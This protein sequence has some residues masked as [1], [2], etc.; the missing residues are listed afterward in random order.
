VDPRHREGYKSEQQSRRESR[1]DIEKKLRKVQLKAL[2]L[3]SIEPSK[4]GV[5]RWLSNPP[6]R[7]A[8]PGTFD[9]VIKAA[10]GLRLIAP[11]D[12]LQTAAI[13]HNL[14]KGL[15]SFAG[16]KG[17]DARDLEKTLRERGMWREEVF[18]RSEITAAREN[19][20]QKL[21][22][23]LIHDTFNVRSTPSFTLFSSRFTSLQDQLVSA[24]WISREGIRRSPMV[25]NAMISIAMGLE[26]LVEREQGTLGVI[27]LT[28]EVQSF[29]HQSGLTLPDGCKKALTHIYAN[30][31]DKELQ[32]LIRDQGLGAEFEVPQLHEL[33]AATDQLGLSVR[34]ELQRRYMYSSQKTTHA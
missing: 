14:K 11:N 19:H 2:K 26:K 30:R 12:V 33:I 21:L 20:A 17:S 28:A 5:L 9:L 6:E 16:Y 3:F 18:P 23:D 13:T 34:G 8:T 32:T 27:F 15:T 24:G 31:I 10:V 22:A 1:S 7:R 29:L 4:E 25:E